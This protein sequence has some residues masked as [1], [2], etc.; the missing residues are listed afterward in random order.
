M[1]E[2]EKK[3]RADLQVARW[4]Y[5]NADDIESKQIAYR[6]VHFIEALLVE[7]IAQHAESFDTFE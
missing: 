1:T 2:Y 5:Y 6:T 4:H 7:T 3:I